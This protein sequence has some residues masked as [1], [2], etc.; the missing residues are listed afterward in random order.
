VIETPQTLKY[1]LHI[2]REILLSDAQLEFVRNPEVVLYQNSRARGILRVGLKTA[3][4]VSVGE[5]I[6]GLE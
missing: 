2:A 5:R 6:E 4:D 3:L 1:K